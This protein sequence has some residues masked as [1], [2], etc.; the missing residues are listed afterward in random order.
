MWKECKDL[1]EYIVGLRRD[2]H[3]IPELG[4]NLPETSDYVA[5]ALDKLNIPYVRSKTDSGI[6]ATIE[7]GKPGKTICLRADMDA[8][9]ITEET[10][11]PFTSKHVGCMHA[12][13][14]DSHTAMLLGAGKVLWAHRAELAGTVRLLFQ[15][16][17]EQSRGAEVMIANGG[18]EGADAVFGT[19]IGTIIDKTIPSGTFIVTPGCC[20]AAF[21]KFHI[22]VK[23]TGC[24][25]STP[26][27]GVD[28]INIA[29][30][31]VLALQAITT[32]EV[33]ATRPLVLT[34]GKIEGGSQYNIIPNEVVIEG[35]IRTLEE[36]LRQYAA[37]RIGEVAQAT[38]QVFG[39]SVDYEM[40][41]GAPPVINDE[42]MAAL[43]ANSA[44]AVLGGDMVITQVKA[45][46]MGGEDFAYYLEKVPGAFM[47]LSSANPEKG[48]DVAHH[49][50]KFDVDEDVFWEG[51][52]VFVKIVEDFLNS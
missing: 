8:L 21:D 40:V 11:L 36:D 25:G 43:A 24:H 13:G 48:T 34:I 28:P 42:A 52:A 49:N 10:G 20:M 22:K 23:G 5:A 1:Q 39:G 35:T 45:P 29:A 30:H 19:H 4:L 47:F 14:H 37:R 12:C 31:I 46:N 26:E 6:I 32:R 41:W 51:A 9:P 38:A 2:L 27:K 3:Q 16:S 50:P 7:G 15:T 33:N 17:E 18:V 44:K